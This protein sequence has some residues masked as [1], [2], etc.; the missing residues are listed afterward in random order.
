MGRFASKIRGF[1]TERMRTM[2]KRMEMNTMKKIL[3][4]LIMLIMISGTVSGEDPAPSPS[5]SLLRLRLYRNDFMMPQNYEI[6]LLGDAYY[7]YRN[8]DL[9]LLVDPQIADELVRII[10]KYDIRS[11]DGFDESN[12]EVDDGEFFYFTAVLTDGTSIYAHGE[13]VFPAA[14]DPAASMMEGLILR[15]D[16]ETI[17][18]DITGTYVY[19]GEGFGG[20]FTITISE[21]GTYSFY[22]G[23]LSSYLGGGSWD[24]KS[25]SMILSEENG[26]AMINYF[27][28]GN[29][30]LVFIEKGSDNFPYIT[31]PDGGRFIRQ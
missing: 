24:K 18:E 19:E 27:A 20:E 1:Y 23:P 29:N 26:K 21:D 30:V 2:E 31:V 15:A 22:E 13:N 5:G 25:G 3:L 9:P 10:D 8:D 28:A 11:W 7:L 16:G 6:Y 12:P 4:L 14:Y 17:D